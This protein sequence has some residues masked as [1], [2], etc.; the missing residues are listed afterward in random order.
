VTLGVIRAAVI[1]MARPVGGRVSEV[2]VA[3]SMEEFNEALVKI[4]RSSL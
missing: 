4:F 2:M 1:S 3:S